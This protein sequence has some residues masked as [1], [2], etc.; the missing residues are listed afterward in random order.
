MAREYSEEGFLQEIGNYSL[1]EQYFTSRNITGYTYTAGQHQSNNQTVAEI[2]AFMGQQPD[3]KR[4]S[5]ESDFQRIN[6]MANEK[7]VLNL[8]S[9]AADRNIALPMTELSQ[10]NNYDKAF[11]F[12][13][14]YPEVFDNADAVQQFLDLTGWKRTPAPTKAPSFV[15]GK[16]NQLEVA[17][18][19]YF[20]QKEAKGKYGSV[21]MYQKGNN[22]YVVARLTDHAEANFVPEEGT[23]KVIQN[24]THRPIFEIYYLYR[25]IN[26]EEGSELEIKAKGGFQK[27]QELLGVFLKAVFGVDFDDT[28]QTFNLD[29]IKN[30]SFNLITE[31]SDQ[32]EWWYLKAIDMATPDRKSQ[33]RVSLRDDTMRETRAMWDQLSRLDLAAR[34]NNMVINRVEMKIKY[35]PVRPRQKGTVTF[36]INWK[37]SC[38]LNGTDEFHIR[39]RKILKKSHL[40]CGFNNP[41]AQQSGNPTPRILAQQGISG[42]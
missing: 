39:T 3:G 12:F 18:K 33:I 1:I 16:K 36:N 8:L 6:N 2:R 19:N 34:M 15:L 32:V 25:K 28:R 5:T 38:S 41:T 27:Q 29:L 23:S 26:T 7:G 31:A 4:Q 13:L 22:V 40:D 42:Q 14:N 21:E 35:T 20:L 10:M 30:P 11:W 17:L 24:G 9:E 37:D